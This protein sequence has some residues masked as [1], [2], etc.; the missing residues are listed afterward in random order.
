M[1]HLFL[2]VH[3]YFG[4]FCPKGRT[5]AT[6]Y[7]NFPPLCNVVVAMR[8]VCLGRSSYGSYSNLW[9]SLCPPNK[10]GR[11]I[12]Q[13]I[14]MLFNY[15]AW[16]LMRSGHLTRAANVPNAQSRGDKGT[17]GTVFACLCHPLSPR[18]NWHVPA[19]GCAYGSYSE[20]SIA[21]PTKWVKA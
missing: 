15:L 8:R 9:Q 18:S 21:M 11:G 3:A 17:Y 1:R 13:L 14:L 5:M 12:R 10:P 7:A 4:R 16:F 19:Y 20:L 6:G 2:V